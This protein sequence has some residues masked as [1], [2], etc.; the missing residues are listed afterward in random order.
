MLP[1]P[2]FPAFFRSSNLDPI[3]IDPHDHRLP[4]TIEALGP[5]SHQAWPHGQCSLETWRK[6]NGKQQRVQ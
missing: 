6:K 3:T 5:E 2:S 1:Y 4:N